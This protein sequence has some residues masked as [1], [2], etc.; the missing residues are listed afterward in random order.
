MKLYKLYTVLLLV[1]VVGACTDKFEDINTKPDAFYTDEV[2]GKFFMTNPQFRLF[3]PDRF[4]YWRAHLI[5]AD[6]YSGHVCFGH[7]GSWWSDELGYSYSSSYTDATW[8]WMEGYLGNLDNFMKLVDTGGEFENEYMYAMG[9]IM[10]GLYYQMFTDIFGMVPYT[11][12]ADPDIVTPD[13]DTQKTIYKGIIADLDEAMTIIGDAESTGV[14]VDDAG[15]ND[16]Y[17][18]GEL[19][20]WKKMANT[21]KLRIALRALGANGDDFASTA[22]EQALLGPLM[23]GEGDNCLMEKDAEISQW[24][25]AAYGDVWHNFGTGSDWTLGKTLI[26]LLRDEND[27]RLS[28]YAKPAKGGKTKFE[29]PEGEEGAF[30]LKRVDFIMAGLDEAGVDYTRTDYA[31][32]VLVEMPIS[33]YYVGQPTRLNGKTYPFAEYDFFSTPVDYVIQKKN[34]GQQIAPE[35]VMLT[36]EAYFLRAEAAV[37]GFGGDANMLYQEGI[38]QAMAVWDVSGAE[39]DAYIGSSSLGSLTGVEDE[40]LE[41]IATQ[42]WIAAFTDGFEAWAVVRDLGYPS[43][44][45]EGVSDVDIFGLGDINGKYPQRMRYGNQT[46]NSNGDKTQEAVNVQGADRQDTKLWWAN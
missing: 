21:L 12:A 17:F 29:K 1:A 44:L 3:A 2:S 46:W 11:Q 16:L 39:A 23:E 18:G 42:R 9:L 10:K 45:A 30:F 20:L 43:V 24:G 38:R 4:P 22:I 37:R 7:N 31:D 34:E 14:G 25:S 41:K 19:Q 8:G 6:R 36:A 33:T 40:D 27:P 28:K 26:D 15:D 13:F 32:S 5:H 35:I